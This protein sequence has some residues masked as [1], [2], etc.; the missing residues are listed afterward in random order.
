M[1]QFGRRQL[2]TLCCF[3]PLSILGSSTV[4]RSSIGRSTA[5]LQNKW[6]E[7]SATPH[8]VCGSQRWG[9]CGSMLVPCRRTTCSLYLILISLI[10]YERYSASHLQHFTITKTPNMHVS[11]LSERNH[12]GMRDLA[13]SSQRGRHHAA[14]SKQRFRCEKINL[15]LLILHIHTDQTWRQDLGELKI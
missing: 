3:Y 14:T 1:K 11:G 9:Q 5:Q 2:F 15:P 13:Y 12:A 7:R 8:A 4:S 6:V 10:G